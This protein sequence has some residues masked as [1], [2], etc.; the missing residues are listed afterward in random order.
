[1]QSALLGDSDFGV[2]FA[3]I[4]PLRIDLLRDAVAEERIQWRKRVLQKLAVRGI[5]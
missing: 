2:G 1:M 3:A 5:Q 4:K